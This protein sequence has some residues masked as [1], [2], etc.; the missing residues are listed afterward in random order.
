MKG[1]T[2]KTGIKI[3]HKSIGIEVFHFEFFSVIDEFEE[4]VATLQL[5]INC[6]FYPLLIAELKEYWIHFTK[7]VVIDGR[8]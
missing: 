4:L 1:C 3:Y 6:N 7:A 2:L 8:E 5:I